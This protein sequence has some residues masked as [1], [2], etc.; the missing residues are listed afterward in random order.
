M[1]RTRFTP[2][3]RTPSTHWIGGWVG[4]RA[5]LIINVS[6]ILVGYREG[7]PKGIW[8]STKYWIGSYTGCEHMDWVTLS[9]N[10]VQWRVLMNT[11]NDSWL[12]KRRWNSILAERLIFRR[13]AQLRVIKF[14]HYALYK[15]F[16][17]HLSNW[18]PQTCVS[19]RL[20]TVCSHHCTDT[21]C[22]YTGVVSPVEVLLWELHMTQIMF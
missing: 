17:A 16:S 10:R 11:V 12:H 1:P 15:H 18:H 22:V 8:D 9:P 19:E 13:W 14:L 21:C 4:P 20:T 6:H 7:K 5:G 2:G 3:E